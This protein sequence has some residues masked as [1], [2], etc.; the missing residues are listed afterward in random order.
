MQENGLQPE[1]QFCLLRTL[2]HFAPSIRKRMNLVE[3]TL[4]NSWHVIA[5]LRNEEDRN[6]TS[7]QL[8]FLPFGALLIIFE[9]L[10]QA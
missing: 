10:S 2:L 7:D 6:Q 8:Q 5:H 1:E 3:P 4:E 9:R